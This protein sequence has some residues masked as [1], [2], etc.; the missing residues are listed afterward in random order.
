MSWRPRRS[1]VYGVE[2][3]AQ[4]CEPMKDGWL[5]KQDFTPYTHVFACR[6]VQTPVRS[7]AS[8]TWCQAVT[9]M[10]T[11]KRMLRHC[12]KW[13]SA[14]DHNRQRNVHAVRKA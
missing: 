5:V 14:D 4:G 9:R 1:L 8:I 10:K 11:V 13:E 3:I 6:L 12:R 7:L 2:C